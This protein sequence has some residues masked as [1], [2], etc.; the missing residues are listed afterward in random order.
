MRTETTDAGR[1]APAPAE[2]DRVR[3]IVAD[4]DPIARRAVREA[5]QRD[6]ITVI[7]EPG[8]GYDAA[9]LAIHYRPDVLLM[10][11]YMPRLDGA[12]AATLTRERAPET[13]VV[14]LGPREDDELAMRC[15]RA[16]AIGFLPKTIGLQALVRAVRAA[17]RGEPVF[18]R[19]LVALLLEELRATPSSGAGIR[20]IRSQLTS[21]EWEVLDL[22]TQG[23]STTGIAGR[24]V[25]SNET[26]RSHIK[27]ILRKLHVHSREQAVEKARHLRSEVR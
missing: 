19:R 11:S 4:D 6:G 15:M 8:D 9:Q 10:D 27:H 13:V 20:P 17:A 16:G 22:L 2:R 23:L 24:L 12:E 26:V 7:A 3:V 21:R 18:G 5:L 1:D 25:V 14:V